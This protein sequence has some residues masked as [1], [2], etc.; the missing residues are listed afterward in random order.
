LLPNYCLTV[1]YLGNCLTCTTGNILYNYQCVPNN[2]IA[3]CQNYS[4]PTFTCLACVSGYYLASNSICTL[5]PPNCATAN[6]AGICQQCLSGYTLVGQ[7]CFAI[8]NNCATY[9][10]TG[11][12]QICN[13]GYKLISQSCFAII[14]NCAS[15]TSTGQCQTCNNGYTLVD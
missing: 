7:T 11:Q 4:L 15:Y 1:N 8:I 13:N 2:S 10:S 5:L 6:S 14:P 9:S 3:N 12:C